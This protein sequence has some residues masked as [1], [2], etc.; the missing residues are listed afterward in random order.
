MLLAL[1]KP[2]FSA[3]CISRKFVSL[4]HPF[5]CAA[6]SHSAL[7]SVEALSTTTISYCAL[8]GCFMMLSMHLARRSRPFQL[9]MIIDR[10]ILNRFPTAGAGGS[11]NLVFTQI[12][13]LAEA[14]FGRVA[15]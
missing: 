3:F 7:P 2:T 14:I 1:P 8:G 10:S 13:S 5:E 12:F 9:T 15:T 6:R 11:F 4:S